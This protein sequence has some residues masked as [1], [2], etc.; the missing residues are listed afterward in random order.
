MAW[1]YL[2]EQD[3]ELFREEVSAIANTFGFTD[4]AVDWLYN[5]EVL[6]MECRVAQQ[7]GSK[8]LEISFEPG[9]P[10]YENSDKKDGLSYAKIREKN[11]R[12][13]GAGSFNP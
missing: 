7:D 13:E 10:I 12:S 2:R 5:S 6:R 1:V 9:F 4:P 8:M 3:Q 11:M